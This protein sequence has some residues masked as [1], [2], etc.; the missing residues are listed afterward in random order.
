MVSTGLSVV[1]SPPAARPP[2]AKIVVSAR[3]SAAGQA[4]AAEALQLAY[5]R[6]LKESGLTL[7]DARRLKF[8]LCAKA[9]C[10][11]ELTHKGAGFVIPYLDP[12]GKRTR[13]WRYRYLETIWLR[14]KH[15][16]R[17][18]RYS[19]P[20][21]TAPEAYMPDLKPN[22]PFLIITEGELKAAC[23]CKAGLPTIGLGGVYNF[24][25]DRFNFRLLP[26]LATRNWTDVKVYIIYD[27][28]AHRNWQVCA[29]ENALAAELLAL[30]AAI[31]IVRLPNLEPGKKTGLDD[32]LV[33][34]GKTGA[35]ELLTLLEKTKPWDRSRELH[36]LNEE[37]VYVEDP[38]VVV[39]V[40]DG[41]VMK[42][43]TFAQ[44][45][46][47]DR[48]WYDEV[49]RQVDKKEI[50]RLEKKS[51]AAEWMR[52]PFRARVHEM[53]YAPGQPVI[54]EDNKLNRWRPSGL[55][56]HKA[57][58]ARWFRLQDFLLSELT[59]EQRLYM[60]CW[61]AAPLQ[62]PGTKVFGVPVIWGYTQRTGKS[63]FAETIA[64]LYGRHNYAPIGNNELT[65]KFNSDWAEGRQFVL[66]DEINT[67][68]QDKKAVY[69]RLKA[70]FTQPLVRINKKNQPEYTVPDCL[71]YIFTSNEPD[72]FYMPPE[73]RRFLVV[74]KEGPA[75]PKAFYED[76]ADWRAQKGGLEAILW[77]YLEEFKIPDTFS[78]T[79]PP[80]QTAAKEDMTDLSLN[81]AER[82]VRDML[83]EPDEMLQPH[84]AMGA[85]PDPKHTLYSTA[86]L[87]SFARRF[88][89]GEYQHLE[90]MIGKAMAKYGFKKVPCTRNGQVK[91]P[92][93]GQ[94]CLW[95]LR[96]KTRWLAER[97]PAV[98]RAEYLRQRTKT[99][100]G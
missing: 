64:M 100:N 38:S 80:P 41:Q 68:E 73:D 25:S 35:E 2:S 95:V 87:A 28:E 39:N 24:R 37:V 84:K 98:I 65:G 16:V 29:A 17:L 71:N 70:W 6:K 63:M 57:S 75:L 82:W 21:N 31:Y 46:Y 90:T 60:E 22:P 53:T 91:I 42:C 4:C 15:G 76:F 5:I 66:G 18:L 54:T 32:Y 23:A 19:Q 61:I 10:P 20:Q 89:D 72:C 58:V 81:A 34:K 47:A 50:T 55:E 40:H 97:D 26:A 43:K 67:R 78:A 33:A 9:E 59:D 83:A 96:E 51:A 7:D 30:G 1:T 74:Q 45:R 99:K 36:A 62:K 13:M 69:T 44:E 92:G 12:K 85:K 93:E 79:S 8:R 27:S 88:I 77:H 14:T 52:W 11:A 56:P 94:P 86:Q 49:T 48:I 3:P